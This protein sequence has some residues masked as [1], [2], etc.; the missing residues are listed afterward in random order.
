MKIMLRII[1]SP[2]FFIIVFIRLLYVAIIMTYNWIKYGGECIAYN[3][4]INRETILDVFTELK[5]QKL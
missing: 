4:K 3:E 1:S 5:N 2:A